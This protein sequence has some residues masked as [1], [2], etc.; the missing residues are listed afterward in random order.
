MIQI[1]DEV[2]RA[3]DWDQRK[4]AIIA[5]LSALV[6]TLMLI[7]TAGALSAEYQIFPNGTAYSAAIEITDATQ[8]QFTDTGLLGESIPITVGG[9]QLSGNCSPC[10]FN[11]STSWKGPSTIT[12]GEGDYNISMRSWFSSASWFPTITFAEGNYTISYVGPIQDYHL[13]RTF[14]KPYDINVTFPAE[15]DVRDPLLA[16]LSYGANV[17]RYSNNT[18]LVRWNSTMSFDLRFYDQNHETL[19]FMFGVFWFAIAFILL[20]PFIL[21]WKKFK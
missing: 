15:L 5:L 19:L 6:A 10:R 12:F 16:G 2:M 1:G 9:V 4:P 13:Q 11:W 17:T 21:K 3:T 18:T 14:D 7:P 20:V 8:Y